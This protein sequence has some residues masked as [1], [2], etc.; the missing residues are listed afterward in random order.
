MSIITLGLIPK[1][2]VPGINKFYTDAAKNIPAVYLEFMEK[3]MSDR[4]FEEDVQY[5]GSGLL[6][7]KNE[8]SNLQYDSVRQTNVKR[9]LHNAYS[10]GFRITREARDDGQTLKVAEKLSKELAKSSAHT[11]NTVCTNILNRGFDSR[12][13]GSDGVELFSAAHVQTIN[14]ATGRN[15][16][17]VAS[18]LE[19]A[20]LEQALID[21]A[22]FTDDVGLP[23]L[24]MARKLIVPNALI[25]EADRLVSS[26]KR[27]GSADNDI[28]ASKNLRSLPDGVSVNPYLTDPDA[29]MIITDATDGLKMMERVAPEI[30]LDADFDS[31]DFKYRLYQR[32]SCGWTNWQGAYG[33]EG[34]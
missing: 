28:N 3:Q 20:S 10:L 15:K 9:Y 17:Q 1:D 8:G 30:A 33:S 14:G 16:P 12:Y 19:E 26:D 32:F 22:D 31:M 5:S 13:V 21:I 24:V 29:W 4:A 7:K 34:A 11:M 23:S 2:L 6:K 27:P 25:Y 18:D